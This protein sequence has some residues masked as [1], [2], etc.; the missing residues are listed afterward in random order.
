MPPANYHVTLAF[1]GNQPAALFDGIVLAAARLDVGPVVVTLDRFGHWPKPRVFWLGASACPP[2]LQMLAERLWDGMEDL[3][4]RREQRPFRPHVTLARKV[5]A[6]PE[7]SE[8]DPLIWR[9][10]SFA[11]IESV[12]EQQG[13][14]Y[15]VAK[16]FSLGSSS[17]P[18]HG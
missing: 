9:A 1:L 6:L 2:E 16:E 15:T 4:L 8:P 7:V 3:G 10:S 12:T 17:D 14:R 11:L 18:N 5:T 13:A